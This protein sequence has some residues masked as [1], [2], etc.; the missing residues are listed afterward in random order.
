MSMTRDQFIL[1][2]KAE[3]ESLRRFLLVLCEHDSVMADDIAQDALVKAYMSLDS[4]KGTSKFS[5]WLFRIAY[6]CFIDEKRK[7]V[8]HG[9][10]LGEDIDSIAAQRIVASPS[11]DPS[12]GFKYQAL[13][14]AIDGLKENEK[15]AILLFYMEDLPTKDIAR[16]L[17]AEEGTIR[18]WL[19]RG[20]EH[21]RKQL[22]YE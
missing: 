21:L 5:T 16:I 9:G 6:N 1:Y 14:R 17:D 10:G 12:A 11:D 20:R 15:S 22:K 4:F 8:S 13:Y 7:Q 3:Q 18:V 2:V 19:T